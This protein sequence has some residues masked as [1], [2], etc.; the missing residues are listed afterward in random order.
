MRC[1]RG[2]LESERYRCVLVEEELNGLALE[3]A[4]LREIYETNPR[5]A[6]QPRR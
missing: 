5:R 1:D 2:L 6:L 4:L 3:P